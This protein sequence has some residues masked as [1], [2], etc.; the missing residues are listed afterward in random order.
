MQVGTISVWRDARSTFEMSRER[1]M[2]LAT[3]WSDSDFTEFLAEVLT[4]CMNYIC[5]NLE[6]CLFVHESNVTRV[7]S[8][9]DDPLTC[10]KP[11]TWTRFWIHSAK[12]V[13]V[14][15]S[16]ALNPCIP[17]VYLGFEYCSIQ[18]S[19]RFAERPTANG[20]DGTEGSEFTRRNNCVRPSSTRTVRN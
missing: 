14:K 2:D 9:V 20:V 1:R 19:G 15:R 12:L 4:E 13:V 10:A 17:V 6:R 7:V 11:A 3:A 5:G 18:E 8:H 16:E